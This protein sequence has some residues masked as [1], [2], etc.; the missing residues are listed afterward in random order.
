MANEPR[1]FSPFSSIICLFFSSGPF[2]VIWRIISVVVNPFQSHSDLAQS[3][4]RKEILKSLPTIA[5]LYPTSTVI[6]IIF[7]IF[8]KT[9]IHHALPRYIFCAG[10]ICRFVPMFKMRFSYSLFHVASATCCIASAKMRSIDNRFI[11]TFTKTFPRWFALRS[12][13]YSSYNTQ[14]AECSVG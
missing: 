9:A 14:F 4:I 6:F 2:A 12:Q 8:I 3:H 7:C 5:H 1:L 10:S 13:S 11:A